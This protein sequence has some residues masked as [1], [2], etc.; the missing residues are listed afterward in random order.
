[1][2]RKLLT[3]TCA[4]LIA[5]TSVSV[6]HAY[7][8]TAGWTG[9]ADF[10]FS[11]STG[12]TEK[13]DL[14]FSTKLNKDD[15]DWGHTLKAQVYSAKDSDVRNKEEYRVDWQTRRELS[16]VDYLFGEVGYVNDRFSGFDSRINEGIGYGY[17]F[18]DTEEFKLSGE[19][20]IGGRHTK[21]TTGVKEN[22]ALG[23]LAGKM[24]WKINDNVSFTE[25][26]S[27]SAADSVIIRSESAIKTALSESLYLK[28]GFD[29]EQ[30][31]D[32]PA[33][34][35]ETDTLTKVSVGYKF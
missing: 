15:G 32:V 28:L 14:N 25:D 34:K 2:K 27:I 8:I 21:F 13:E 11:F 20:S 30:N 24:D 22:S 10:G 4:A 19:V 17:K 35:D 31:N 12:N 23:K 6:A 9:E 33:T 1:M 29:I 3:T 26:L 5:A 16:K 7:D 18:Y